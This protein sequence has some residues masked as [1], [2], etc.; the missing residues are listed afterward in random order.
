MDA[1]MS[2]VQHLFVEWGYPGLFISA[3]LAG[4]IV[5]F[6]SEVVLIV[7]IKMGL[8]PFYSVLWASLGNTVGGMSCYYIGYLGKVE[9]AEKYF[10]VKHEKIQKM[11]KFLQ[12]K[13]ALMGF[14]GFLP[15]FGEII[16]MTLG[17]MRSNVIITTASMFVGKLIRYIIIAYFMIYAAHGIS[18][19]YSQYFG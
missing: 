12:G 18:A 16:A 10:K 17:F 15:T 7:L 1:L 13:G 19:L 2:T 5:P 14:F 3:A 9:W 4:S 8:D 6:S 11:Q